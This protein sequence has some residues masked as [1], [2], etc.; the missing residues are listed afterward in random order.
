MVE[1]RTS[2]ATRH[3]LSAFPGEEL[4]GPTRKHFA[5][6]SRA[7]RHR[8]RW[9]QA[10]HDDAT[11]YLNRL[12]DWLTLELEYAQ[13]GV[14]LRRR[15]ANAMIPEIDARNNSVN[16]DRIDVEYAYRLDFG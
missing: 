16:R 2:R 7:W 4:W 15:E 12:V 13:T 11:A 14:D 9:R 10:L 5:L 8:R 6:S 3:F 1:R